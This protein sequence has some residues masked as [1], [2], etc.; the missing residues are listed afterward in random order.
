MEG[1]PI[2]MWAAGAA[3][4]ALVTFSALR[5]RGGPSVAPAGPS[6]PQLAGRS[7]GAIKVSIASSST[8]QEWLH[9]AVS[10]FNAASAGQAAL[11]VGGRPVVVEVL[12]E[13]IDGKR[14]DYRSGTMVTD[15]L[16]GKIKP[17][18]I[19]PG[20]ESWVAQLQREW[21]TFSGTS[22]VRDEAPVLA[23]TPLV[24]AMWQ[25]RARALGCWPAAQ[26]QCTW[27][28]IRD[29]ASDPAGWSLVGKPEWHQLKLGYSYFGESNSGTLGVVAMC[30]VG[31]GKT[32]GLEMEDVGPHTGCGE[33]I[34]AVETAKVHS[35]KKSDWLLERMIQG[36]PDYLDVALT[37]ESEV[38]QLNQKFAKDLREPIVAVYPQDGTMLVGHPYA[39][40]DGAPWVTVEQAAGARLLRA[41]LLG[42]DQQERIVAGGLRPADAAVRL[43]PPIASAFGA[44]PDARLVPLEVPDAAVVERIGE[45]W[46]EVRKHA[47]VALVFDKSGSMQSNGKI[48][49]AS[50]GANEFVRE[51]NREDILLWMPFDDTVYPGT[52][53][54]NAEVGERLAEEISAI[55]AS[56]GTALYD[57]VLQAYER[58]GARRQE[59][60]RG[61]RYG[62]VVLSDGRDESSKRTLTMLENALRPTENDPRGIQVHTIAIG[63]DADERVLRRISDAAHGRFWKGQNEKE[64]VAIYREIAKHY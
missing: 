54:R 35:G 4:I 13:E 63:S 48:R 1:R 14:A 64:L 36:G 31:A 50:R 57:A 52:N 45:V 22:I 3:L 23:R 19:S 25:S 24:L 15:T 32:G 28:R 9:A 21:R 16:A 51:M 8:K 56:G 58:V 6:E 17:T 10:A 30:L 34:G 29:I 49:S 42:R 40:L 59:L 37:W 61:Y 2:W 53:G 33:L 12:Q 7:G 27:Q 26:A 43:A 47:V 41:F 44:N 39:V 38:I 60:G 5:A 20:E 46:Q 55:G 62:I 18:V 11:Q